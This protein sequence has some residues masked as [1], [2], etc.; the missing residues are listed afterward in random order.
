MR[1]A[2]KTWNAGL[3]ITGKQ[4]KA[5]DMYSF[6]VILYEIMCRQKIVYIDDKIDKTGY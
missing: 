3:N 4:G 6:G 2:L 1:K 5:A